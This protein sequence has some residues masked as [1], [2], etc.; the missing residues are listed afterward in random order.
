MA[1]NRR[2]VLRVFGEKG[3]R[4]QHQG[5][6]C[7]RCE[8]LGSAVNAQSAGAQCLRILEVSPTNSI[9]QEGKKVQA[10][11]LRIG[12]GFRCVGGLPCHLQAFCACESVVPVPV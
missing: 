6:V 11:S 9:V 12:V 4:V 8:A 3:A 10:V 7:A 1:L 2:V 5:S